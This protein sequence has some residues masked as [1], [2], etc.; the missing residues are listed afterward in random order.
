MSYYQNQ[1][2]K[3]SE[4]SSKDRAS[5][6]IKNTITWLGVFL[7]STVI[8]LKIQTPLIA[9]G[10]SNTCVAVAIFISLYMNNHLVIKMKEDEIDG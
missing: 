9:I 5:L 4:I 3:D 10:L 7:A 2:F 8:F 1:D 6:D